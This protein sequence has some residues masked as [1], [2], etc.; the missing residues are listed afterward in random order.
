MLLQ[1]QSLLLQARFIRRSSENETPGTGR[2]ETTQPIPGCEL[3]SAVTRCFKLSFVVG[4][5]DL[6]CDEI[7]FA[8]SCATLNFCSYMNATPTK[9]KICLGKFVDILIE[10]PTSKKIPPSPYYT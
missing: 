10:S 3:K 1:E 2:I 8:L 4:R 6:Q 9:E 7:M 5:R